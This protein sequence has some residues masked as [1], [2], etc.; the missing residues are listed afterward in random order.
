ML[1]P[2][3]MLALYYSGAAYLVALTWAAVLHDLINDPSAANRER[4]TRRAVV[5]LVAGVA[6]PVFAL[7]AWDIGRQLG[8]TDTDLVD[9]AATR[10]RRLAPVVAFA[11][12][13]AAAVLLTLAGG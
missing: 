12:A 10:V 7:A 5:C 8:A 11:S 3:A 1:A 9:D 4:T 13:S 6:H 2:K